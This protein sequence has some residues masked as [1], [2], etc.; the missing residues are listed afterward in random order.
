MFKHTN[1]EIANAIYASNPNNYQP[2]LYGDPEDLPNEFGVN[3]PS[4]DPTPEE[5]IT[6]KDQL[7]KLSE[8]ARWVIT[9][10]INTPAELVELIATPLGKI[11]QRTLRTFLMKKWRS[12]QK[13]TR[14]FSEIQ[15][16]LR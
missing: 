5:V 9:L 14:V 10:C 16:F 3:P 12:P 1:Y 15:E 2:I 11:T 6:K 4:K 13:I 8:E 7:E